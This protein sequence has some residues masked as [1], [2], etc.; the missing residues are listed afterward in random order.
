[1]RRLG[2]RAQLNWRRLPVTPEL[3]LELKLAAVVKASLAPLDVA[4]IFLS[5]WAARRAAAWHRCTGLCAG[6]CV[7]PR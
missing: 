1:M 4:V 5:L 7:R 3:S 6:P 2:G